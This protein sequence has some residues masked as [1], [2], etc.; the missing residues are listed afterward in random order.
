LIFVNILAILIAIAIIAGIS[1]EDVM[2]KIMK[3]SQVLFGNNNQDSG[4]A[5]DS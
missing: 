1:V 3:V 4:S 2:F 5:G